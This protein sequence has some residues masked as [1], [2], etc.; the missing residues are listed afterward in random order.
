V[1]NR[2]FRIV[3]LVLVLLASRI[4]WAGYEVVARQY[5]PGTVSG[6]LLNAKP[7]AAVAAGITWFVVTLVVFV[8]GVVLV[9]VSGLGP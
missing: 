9:R 8:G 3:S 4:G 6:S 7:G 1:P 2:R 5:G